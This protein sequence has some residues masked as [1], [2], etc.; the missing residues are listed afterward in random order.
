MNKQETV[1]KYG[2]EQVL[3]WRRSY[4]IPPPP[5][6]ITSP[7]C[8]AND[9]KYSNIAEAAGIRTESLKVNF[10]LLFIFQICLFC[11]IGGISDYSGAR[12]SLLAQ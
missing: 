8:P 10:A 3:T 12:S 1:D 11:E 5:C 2:K 7:H 6:D 4:D 9:P